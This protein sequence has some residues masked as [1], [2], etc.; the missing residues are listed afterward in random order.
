MGKSGTSIIGR[1]EF[2]AILNDIATEKDKVDYVMVFKLY[3]LGRNAADVLQSL[4]VMENHNANPVCVD[5]SL[6][7]YK[8][9]GKLVITVLSAVAKMKRENILS[10]TMEGRKQKARQGKTILPNKSIHLDK[11]PDQGIVVPHQE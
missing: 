6:D 3:R 9:S 4:Q 8:D 1:N 2:I 10:Q 11:A 7:S 5:D